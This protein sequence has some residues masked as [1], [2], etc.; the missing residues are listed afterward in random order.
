M[1]VTALLANPQLDQS[2]SDLILN[3]TVYVSYKRHKRFWLVQVDRGFVAG[4]VA[5]DWVAGL[6]VFFANI[7]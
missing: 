7:V 1:Y 2:T 5:P 3:K 4:V 6:N